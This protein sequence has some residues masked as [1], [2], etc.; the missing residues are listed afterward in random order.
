[1]TRSSVDADAAAAPRDVVGAVVHHDPYPFYAGLVANRAFYRDRELNLWVAASAEAVAAVLTHPAGRVRPVGEAVPA[2]LR[3]S[4]VGEIFGGLVRM[5]DGDA[6]HDVPRSALIARVQALGAGGGR[7][8]AVAEYR[9][10]RLADAVR[11]WGDPRAFMQFAFAL[12]THVIGSLLGVPEDG[13]DELTQ[14]V[15]DLV[16]SFSP[17][18]APVAPAAVAPAGA[19][20]A[21]EVLS[22]GG[23]AVR[24]LREIF[25]ADGASANPGVANVIG[26]LTQAQDATAALMA[27]TL[28]TLRRS[29][30]LL[31]SVERA[32]ALLGDVIEEVVRHDAPVQNTRRYLA[33]PATILGQ[34]LPAATAIL[35]VLAAA[36]RD[37]A[38]NAEPASFQATRPARRSFT[39]G[40]GPHACLGRTLATTI[41]RA[42]VARI[43]ASGVDL[44]RLD[45][46]PAYKPYPNIRLPLLAWQS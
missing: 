6:R 45:P 4:A 32:P 37:P 38:A 16:S 18:V 46:R 17:P 36:N 10:H 20:A 2:V 23:R 27:T 39:F 29:L 31:D 41:A 5:N 14:L 12:P 13:L 8:E 44:S 24:R 11:P 25:A 33:E 21:E 22:R 42:G 40:L 28:L 34:P 26:L 19:G 3:G 30:R 9:A 7:V 35:V 43:L 15:G 1:M